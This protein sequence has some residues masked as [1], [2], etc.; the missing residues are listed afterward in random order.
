MLYSIA[1]CLLPSQVKGRLCS[2][3]AEKLEE[4]GKI[5]T[6]NERQSIKCTTYCIAIILIVEN[7]RTINESII[8]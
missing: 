8:E 5:N 6:V 4:T 3:Q 1:S 2:D 7:F